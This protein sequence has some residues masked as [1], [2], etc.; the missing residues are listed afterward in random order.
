[1][2]NLYEYKG[3]PETKALENHWS[4]VPGPAR[5]RQWL[6]ANRSLAKRQKEGSGPF[7]LE[8]ERPWGWCI[9]NHSQPCSSGALS[10]RVRTQPWPV[11]M[12]VF[13]GIFQNVQ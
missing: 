12:G 9:A 10:P 2:N 7:P 11:Q 8:P 13:I 6:A 1:M 4:K 5:D 3:D